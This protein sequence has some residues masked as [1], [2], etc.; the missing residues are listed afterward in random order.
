MGERTEYAC[1]FG[2]NAWLVVASSLAFLVCALALLT[3]YWLEKR[4]YYHKLTKQDFLPEDTSTDSNSSGNDENFN[5]YDG[6]SMY[7]PKTEKS[8]RK[9]KNPAVSTMRQNVRQRNLE[10][11]YLEDMENSLRDDS[12]KGG[13]LWGNR[14]D[15]FMT[16]E[17]DFDF[18]CGTDADET[19]I[20]SK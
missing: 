20:L 1:E 14:L 3:Y 5:L 9:S 10:C 12:D 11:Q 17:D 7:P 13:T 19:S 6:Y 16:C 15:H 4:Y 2:T 8:G 18:L